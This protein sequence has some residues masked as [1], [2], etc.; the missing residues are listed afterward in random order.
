MS[1]N[2]MEKIK[3]EFLRLDLHPTYMEHE[4]VITSVDAAKTRGFE[5]SQGIKALLFTDRKEHFVVVDVAG[6]KQVDQD[7]V[8]VKMGWSKNSIRMATP[9]KVEEV[10]GCLIGSVPPFGHKA[11][12][13]I[14]VDMGVFENEI[15]TFNIGL[16]THSVKIPTAEMRI[17]FQ[18]LGAEEG[19]FAK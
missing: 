3:S 11:T 7:K 2:E 13:P 15:S 14:L 4:A 6:D 12:L 17:L 16:R 8:A 9:E 19:I 1:L 18:N 5:L 10:T